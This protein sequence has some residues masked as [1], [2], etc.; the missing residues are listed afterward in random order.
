MQFILPGKLVNKHSN[1]KYHILFFSIMKGSSSSSLCRKGKVKINR[2]TNYL[3]VATSPEHWDFNTWSTFARWASNCQDG[4]SILRTVL[5]KFKLKRCF[6]W[7]KCSYLPST[8]SLQIVSY[9][10]FYDYFINFFRWLHCLNNLF[11]LAA[12]SGH[13]YSLCMYIFNF[14]VI[15]SSRHATL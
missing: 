12:F 15:C 8:S 5:R 14:H 9:S 7:K 3:K 2:H 1:L 13:V 10:P 4:Q 11:P 6:S